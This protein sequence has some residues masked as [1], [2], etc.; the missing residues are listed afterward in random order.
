MAERI[1]VINAGSSSIKF[2][3][4]EGEDEQ[5]LF[6]GQIENIGVA[7]KL[8]AEDPE[9]KTVVENEWQAS[10]LDHAKATKVI[11]ETAISLLGGVPVA[12]VGHRVVHG[13]TEFTEPIVVT[14]NVV[15]SL[16][17][18]C[19]LAP[20]HQPH[21]LAAIETIQAA[22][23]HIPQV[24]CFDTAFHQTQAPIAQTFA[25]PRELTDS[26]IRRYGFHGLSYEFVSGRLR[27]VAPEYADKKIII[28][29]LGNGAS[30]CAL[31]HGRSVATT[32]GFTAVEG[33][34]MG[35]RCGSIDPGVLIYLLDEKGL[36]ARGLED[37]VY[38]KSGLLGVSGISS[39]MRTLRESSCEHRSSRGTAA[40]ASL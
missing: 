3:L 32:M 38:K 13:G 30:L 21:N 9:G 10:D 19:P 25:L 36:D 40:W 37:L 17:A 15:A 29:H 4:F 23:P 14:R 34:M 8:T 33:L 22:A 26:G 6:R 20:L 2:A 12:G 24:A 18:L 5:L 11:L 35:T 27:T 39:D 7:P 1:A 16:K 28:A 31:E